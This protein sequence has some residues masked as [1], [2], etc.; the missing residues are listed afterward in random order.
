MK[1]KRLAAYLVLIYI[2]SLFCFYDAFISY[3]KLYQD[4]NIYGV[5]FFV[6]LSI[7]AESSMVKLKHYA[8]SSGFAITVA[9]FILFGP[10]WAMII[11]ASGIAL[12]ILK[13][14]DKYIH[15]LNTPF[16]KTMFN[17]S[18]M[19]ISI[20]FASRGYYFI[21]YFL[22][23]ANINSALVN[24]C[25]IILFI[26]IFQLVNTLIIS[27]LIFILSRNN[28]FSVYYNNLK[29]S[30]L[31]ILA[32][33]PFGII[34]MYLYKSFAFLGIIIIMIPVLLVRYTYMLYIEAK[35]K[36]IQTIDVLM[37]AVEAR[38]QYTEGHSRRVADIVEV[39]AKELKL[40]ESRIEQLTLASLVH[41]VGKIGIDDNI[42]NKPGKLTDEEYNI[43]KAHPQIGYNILKDIKDFGDIPFLALHHHERYD[44]KGY[45]EGKDG[46]ELSIDVF[47]IQLADSI[48]AMATDR[49][50]RKALS[51]E[52][53][54]D[55]INKNNGT[56]F[57]PVVVDAYFNALK[58]PNKSM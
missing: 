27:M 37:H 24:T 2:V 33:A 3:Q 32:M 42:L 20:Y 46:K 35:S 10:F 1:D 41:D 19:A 17:S 57:H 9:S 18:E 23:N 34:I 13:H 51:Q 25:A 47:I 39:I 45:P 43:I 21:K 52:Q 38:D 14:N 58:K 22:Y 44:G 28:L 50:Y 49:P 5:S 53:I 12:R 36:Y 26:T 8:V 15:I 30:I 6:L 40:G 7:V 56:Q 54:M 11:V 29:F 48:D 31:N 16:Y 55:E 4:I